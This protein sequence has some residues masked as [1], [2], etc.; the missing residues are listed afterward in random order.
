M[1]LINCPECNTAISDSAITC[2]HCGYPIKS[3]EISGIIHLHWANNS[4]DSLRKTLV[5]VDNVQRAEMQ[6]EDYVDITVSGGVHALELRQKKLVLLSKDVEIL[7]DNQEEFIAY[8]EAMGFSHVKLKN[9]DFDMSKYYSMQAAPK[10]PNCGSPQ[11]R[12]ITYERRSTSIGLFGLASNTLGKS[13]ECKKCKY[14][15]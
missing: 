15:W 12:K 11:I 13:F 6:C 7:K 8:K 1:A 10:C 9:V 3:H 5:F 14:K 2:P 4:G